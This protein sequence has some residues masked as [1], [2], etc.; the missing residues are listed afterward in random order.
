MH[1]VIRFRYDNITLATIQYLL[2]VSCCE[3]T[4]I[5]LKLTLIP[6]QC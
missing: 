1:S 2:S 4:D 6:S 3:L 5:D